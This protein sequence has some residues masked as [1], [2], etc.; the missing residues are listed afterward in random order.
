MLTYFL[1][2][3]TNLPSEISDWRLVPLLRRWPRKKEGARFQVAIYRDHLT[4][5]H[6]LLLVLLNWRQE[7]RVKETGRPSQFVNA[8]ERKKKKTKNP[9]SCSVPNLGRP[10]ITLAK[11]K[12]S[13]STKKKEQEKEKKET[14]GG[15]PNRCAF[16]L[17]LLATILYDC[18]FWSDKISINCRQQKKENKKNSVGRERGV[19]DEF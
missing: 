6:S 12:G 1:K 10:S 19:A 18:C 8:S 2:T 9:G 7:R 15:A 4:A 16:F 11:S 17:F 13:P 3:M 5:R 14:S